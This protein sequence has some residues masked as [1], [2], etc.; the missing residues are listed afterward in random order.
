MKRNNFFVDNNFIFAE[1]IPYSKFNI[2]KRDAI[3]TNFIAVYIL[4]FLKNT[5]N[6]VEFFHRTLTN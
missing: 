5:E 1:L 2:R 3:F 4:Y 6:K